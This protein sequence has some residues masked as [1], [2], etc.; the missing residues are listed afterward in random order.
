MG[1]RGG[2]RW[3]AA[4]AAVAGLLLNAAFLCADNVKL[5]GGGSLNGSVTAG[6][7]VVSV[8]TS[9]GAVIVFDRAEVKQIT[10]GHTPA[11]KTAANAANANTKARPKKRKLTDEEEAW[12]P[13]SARSSRG[14]T[15]TT[16]RNLNRPET[17]FLTS[18]T[19]TRSPRLACIWG[20]A[21]TRRPGTCLSSFFTT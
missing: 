15:G 2:C 9:S 17:L 21:A 19:R 7:K 12:M 10:R 13:R 3:A 18:M 11:P 8:R 1:V 14:F 20:A 4:V 6:S 16:G 5:D